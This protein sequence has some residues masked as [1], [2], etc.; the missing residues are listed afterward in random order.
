[1]L[2][3]LICWINSSSFFKGNDTESTALQSYIYHLFKELA[4][5]LLFFVVL[6]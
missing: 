4:E 6:F 3:M 2:I 5:F 1:M